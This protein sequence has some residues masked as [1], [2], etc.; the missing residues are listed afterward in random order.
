MAKK[1]ANITATGFF[2]LEYN[3]NSK[4][5]KEAYDSYISCMDKTASIEDM[6]KHVAFHI[7]RFG[8]D[9]MVEG[10][11]HVQIAG[12]KKPENFSGITIDDDEPDFSFEI[13]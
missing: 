5:F 8:A 1:I 11:G 10:V 4:E 13:L 9:K 12:R 3:P 6:L 2:T 7:N